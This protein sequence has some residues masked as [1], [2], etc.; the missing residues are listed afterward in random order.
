MTHPART[1]DILFAM[2]RWGFVVLALVVGCSKKSRDDGKLPEPVHA[3]D[4]TIAPGPDAMTMMPDAQASLPPKIFGRPVATACPKTRPPGNARPGING[5]CKQDSDCKNG[6]NGR[7]NTTGPRV[8]QNTCSFD[9][10]FADAD[11]TTG[12][13]CECNEFAGN[14]CLAGNCKTD[15]DCGANGV[16]SRSNPIG[17]GGG[18]PSYFCRTAK[19]TCTDYS[20]C[21]RNGP[22]GGACVFQ[23]ALGHWACQ[24]YPVCPVG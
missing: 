7:C 9:L 22:R 5:V 18:V 23:S 10:C 4:A 17:C 15:A 3:S 14:H 13:P 2:T 19:D 21:G 8:Q 1:P 12:G 11:C 20:D 16:C 6:K 24:E